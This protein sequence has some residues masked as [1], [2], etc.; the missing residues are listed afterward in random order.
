MW[1][2]L[3]SEIL[4]LSSLEL[5]TQVGIVAQFNQVSRSSTEQKLLDRGFSKE[6]VAYTL[7]QEKFNQVNSCGI[8]FT[9]PVDVPCPHFGTYLTLYHS[10]KKGAM[11]FQGPVTDQPAHIIETFDLLDQ[12]YHEAEVKAREQAKKEAKRGK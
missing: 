10:F 9:K 8:T 5:Q 3:F 2:Y 4:N 7:N 12:L 1:E 6:Q 11:P